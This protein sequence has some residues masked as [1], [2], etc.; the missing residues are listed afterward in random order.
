M[1]S[2]LPGPAMP[3][4]VP[5]T[6]RERSSEGSSAADSRDGTAAN[7][8]RTR[9]DESKRKCECECEWGSCLMGNLRS[10]PG[11]ELHT[12]NPEAA[13]S[14]PREGDG[15]GAKDVLEV[16]PH[17]FVALAGRAFE[18]FPVAD[19]DAP[20]RIG[21]QPRLLEGAGCRRHAGPPH[22]EHE[23]ERLVGE[24]EVVLGHAIVCRQEPPRA[25]RVEMVE[26]VAGDG[27]A[28]R[29]EQGVRVSREIFGKNS[30]ARDLGP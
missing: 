20:L 24:D 16:R 19:R 7:A 22:A 28:A 17:D 3:S 2:W 30:A 14:I 6:R 12:G 9:I 11:C 27:L 15:E 29:G 8:A 21:D 4:Q 10:P 26:P 13:E 25:A 23:G 18:P 5:W 1:K